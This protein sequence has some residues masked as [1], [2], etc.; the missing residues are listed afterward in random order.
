MYDFLYYSVVVAFVLG[1]MILVH[2]FGHF[3][4]AKCPNSCT[5]IMIPSTKATATTLTRKL[6]IQ[7][8]WRDLLTW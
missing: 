4:A 2:E 7:I 3:A 1:V 6:Y 8:L 5:R